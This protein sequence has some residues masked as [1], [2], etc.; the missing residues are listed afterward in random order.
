MILNRYPA[1]FVFLSPGYVKKKACPS[2]PDEDCMR[3]GPEQYVNEAFQKPQC[4]ACVSCAKGLL[5]LTHTSQLYSL[6]IFYL[7]FIYILL[8]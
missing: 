7:H 4:D 6:C 3:C 2:D 5:S 8:I 1:Y